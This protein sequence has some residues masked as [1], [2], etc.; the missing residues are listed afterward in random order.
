[1]ATDAKL[2]IS[3]INT[4]IS[5][6]GNITFNKRI[7][8]KQGS[9]VASNS[10]ITLGDGNFFVITGTTDISAISISDWT[11]GSIV[12]LKFSGVLTLT[13]GTAGEAMYLQGATNFTTSANDIL[14]FVLDSG[15][16]REISRTNNK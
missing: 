10:K 6:N 4:D 2:N 8:G 3:A 1:M 14:T 16:W 13:H 7:L 12:T 11:N 5:L 15:L 9:N